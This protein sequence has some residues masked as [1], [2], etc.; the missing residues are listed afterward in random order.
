MSVRALYKCTNCCQ[1]DDLQMRIWV[2]E[3]E[4]IL[5]VPPH[6]GL[7]DILFIPLKLPVLKELIYL[8]NTGF[9]QVINQP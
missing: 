3:L 2:G 8:G 9:D 4:V 5:G 7:S 1:P 6:G